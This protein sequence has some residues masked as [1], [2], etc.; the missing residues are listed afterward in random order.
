MAHGELLAGRYALQREL[1]RG[2][3]G[4]VFLALDTAARDAPRAIKLVE[5][6]TG[7]GLRWE[8]GV[9]SALAHPNLARVYELLRLERALPSLDIQAGSMALVTELAEGKP[10]GTRATELQRDP[11]A[12][13]SLV[14]VVADGVARALSLLHGRGLVHGDVKPDNVVVSDDLSSCK[15]VDFGLAAEATA[16]GVI[17]GSPG[18]MAPELFRGERTAAADLYALGVTLHELL[19]GG[20][21]ADVRSA[22]PAEH[23]QAAM[24]PLSARHAL[25]PHV[26]PALVSLLQELLEPD[27]VLRLRRAAEVSARVAVIAVQH[28]VALAASVGGGADD[29]PTAVER[30]LAITALPF[31]GHTAALDALAEALG[32]EGAVVVCG[33]R[34]SGRSRLVR[35]A[36][37]RMQGSRLEAEL[38]VPTYRT[39]EGLPTGPLAADCVLHLTEA[40]AVTAAEVLAVLRA[41]AVEGRALHLVL[42]RTSPLP[43]L[44][45]A[46][47]TLEPLT[48][49]ET[50]RLLEHALPGTRISAA[51]VREAQAASFGLSGR[52]CRVVARALSASLDMGRPASLRTA[53]SELPQTELPASAD[54]RALAEL[55]AV[56]G[57]ELGPGAAAAAL[58]SA[59]ALSAAYRVLLEAGLGRRHAERFCLRADLVSSLRA[60]L[61]AERVREIGARLPQSELDGRAR[62]HVHAAAGE[63]ELAHRAFVEE[64]TWLRSHGRPEQAA[65]C[66]SEGL[67]VAGEPSGGDALHLCLADALRAQGR[68]REARE[69]LSSCATPRADALHAELARLSGERERATTLATR[70]LGNAALDAEVAVEAEATLA[71]LCYDAGEIERALPLASAAAARGATEPTALRALEVEVL[72]HLHRGDHDRARSVLMPALERARR[73]EPRAAEARLTSL[74]A[75]LARA[76]GDAH[77][78]ARSYAAAFDLAEAAGEQHAAAAFLHNV[79]VQRL[80]CGEP[81]PAISALREAARRLARLGRDADTGR[82]L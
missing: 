70:A 24:R 42:E 20:P 3:S 53:A 45:A 81:G 79:G 59:A 39:S 51:H 31:T 5:A 10:S 26:P 48:E 80:E 72:S 19:R 18:Y 49:G 50:R 67:A 12:L 16:V 58:G 21:G 6:E 43:D 68:Y 34:G 57:G 66:A 11:H 23:L 62:A 2:A 13:L 76:D 74:L 7:A 9:L 54:A 52:L 33:P 82:V 22:T 35:E 78:A 14:L 71:R 56:A 46:R 28:G 8:L 27:P 47:V 4:R 29:A 36:V 44:D 40:D 41:A 37:R 30:A 38:S 55:L 69:A 77:G 15:L 17:A 60:S 64:A 63:L 25:P 65:L 73:L 61:S 1:G 32:R 75:E